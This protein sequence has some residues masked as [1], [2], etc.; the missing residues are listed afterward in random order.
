MVVTLIGYRGCGKS[1]IAPRLARQLGWTWVD[2]DSVVE[3]RAGCSISELFEHEGE[4]AFRKLE[5][6][7]IA[8]L[9]LQPHIVIA[10]G[11]GAILAEKNR[12]LMKSAGPVVW[13]KVSVG[14][15]AKRLGERSSVQRRPSLT[16][17]PIAEEVADVLAVREPVYRETATLIVDAESMRPEQV[18]RHIAR[19]ITEEIQ[20]EPTV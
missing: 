7:V 10:S 4:A 8:D 20:E 6:E 11:G 14:T 1:S 2:S 5:S 17:R 15:L 12:R 18:A 9:V 16:G 3:Q 19:H 13:L